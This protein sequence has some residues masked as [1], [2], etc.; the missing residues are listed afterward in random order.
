MQAL[1]INN[2]AQ[3]FGRMGIF[4]TWL[5]SGYQIRFNKAKISIGP[6]RMDLGFGILDDK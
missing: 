4:R 2:I 3:F 5:R 6:N 1:A